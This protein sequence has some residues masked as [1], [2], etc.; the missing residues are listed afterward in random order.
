MPILSKLWGYVI[1]AG[2]LILAVLA[3]VAG[4]RR[5]GAKAE[6]EEQTEKALDQAKESNA[7]DKSVRADSDDTVA[8]KL[9][10]YTRD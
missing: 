3:A 2:A 4:I 9:R 7:I 5:S 6:R 8:D 1:A 10:R